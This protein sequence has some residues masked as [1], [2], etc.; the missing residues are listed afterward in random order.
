MNEQLEGFLL[1]VPELD[2]RKPS[3][4][5]DYFVYFLTVIGGQ[6]FAK[7]VDVDKCFDLARLP[8]YSNSSAYLLSNSTSKN[9][10]NPKFIRTAKGYQLE[11][12]KQLELQKSLH[13]GPAKVETS[14]LLRGLVS[15]VKSSQEKTFLQEAIDC[16]EIGARRAAIVMV[17]ILTV[18]H[19]YQYIFNHELKRFNAALAKRKDKWI[20]IKTVSKI[21]D[22]AEIPESKFIEIARSASVI[23]NDVRKILDVKLGIRNSCGHP[24]GV[25]VSDV[26]ATDFIMD[27]IENV[28]VKFEV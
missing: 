24:S 14:H 4:L 18:Y 11:R 9:R 7:A 22:F 5:I 1:Q 2:S 3:E 8:R 15:K 20:K 13:E 21:D 10:R 26:K 17:W 23:S 27:L 19:L 6:E 28:I 12:N 25:S 16:Y